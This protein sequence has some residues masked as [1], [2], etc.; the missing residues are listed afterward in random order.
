M[1]SNND[2]SYLI[3]DDLLTSEELGPRQT[4][5]GQMQKIGSQVTLELL[6]LRNQ[7]KVI[8][9]QT[10]SYA[11]HKALDKLFDLLNRQNDRW[12][13]TFMG[14]YGRVHFSSS[15][16]IQLVNLKDMAID[17]DANTIINY[18]KDWVSSLNQVRDQH[19][20][21]SEN[22]DLSNIFDEIFGEINRTC[23]LLSLH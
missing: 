15:D 17:A 14:K 16:P 2:D 11:Q 1:E 3:S 20:N 13:E 4:E 22:S 19:F 7:V 23:Y 10:E 9:W 12:V 5:L 18:L 21:T 8:H 6:R